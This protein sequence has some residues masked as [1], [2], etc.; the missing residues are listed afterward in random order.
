MAGKGLNSV[1]AAQSTVCCCFF[2]EKSCQSAEVPF[3]KADLLLKGVKEVHSTINYVP[4]IIVV[5]CLLT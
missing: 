4:I 5:M 2:A 3:Y 1:L